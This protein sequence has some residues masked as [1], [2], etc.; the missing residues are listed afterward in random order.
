MP[1][2]YSGFDASARRLLTA[3][4]REHGITGE[5]LVHVDHEGL[6]DVGI[7]SVG[8]RLSV[9][10]TVY[11]LKLRDDVPIEEGHWRPPSEDVDAILLD[12]PAGVI[13]PR[14]M[15][16]MLAERDDRIDALESELHR[17]VDVV[18][19]LREEV[20]RLTK[21]PSRTPS[22]R[23]AEAPPRV[24]EKGSDS[25]H[26]PLAA[27]GSPSTVPQALARSQ[28][29]PTPSSMLSL[30]HPN[31][32]GSIPAS[33]AAVAITPGLP[34]AAGTGTTTP[35]TPTPGTPT[36][37]IPPTGAVHLDGLSNSN[38]VTDISI[39][40]SGSRSKDSSSRSGA[41]K[42]TLDDPC[43]KVLPAALRKYKV[44]SSAWSI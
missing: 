9:L 36:S 12:S 35:N 21:R 23:L 8:Q 31:P 26:S 17:I 7:Q 40:V 5:I 30:A 15:H 24:P 10:K 4:L 29:A 22:L 27:L 42:V 25:P 6:K 43:F 14:M 33:G 44:R 13:P 20:A 16:D 3:Q 41:Y 37:S 11:E 39:T 34:S 18:A 32:A 28:P 1:T 19:G 2:G 38:D